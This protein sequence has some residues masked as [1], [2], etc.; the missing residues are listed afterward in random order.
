MQARFAVAVHVEAGGR[1]A[2]HTAEAAYKAVGRALRTALRTESAGIPSTGELGS[3]E[4]IVVHVDASNS[5]IDV[6]D[7]VGELLS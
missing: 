3:Y 2:H 7:A 5:I 4:P 6:D 1:D